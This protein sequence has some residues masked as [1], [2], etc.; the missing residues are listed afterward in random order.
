MAQKAWDEG[1][2]PG[3]TKGRLKR[4]LD[5]KAKKYIYSDVR[6][7][8]EYLYFYV[9]TCPGYVLVTVYQVPNDLKGLIP[10]GKDEV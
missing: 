4:F 9:R 3:V 8:G 7:H 6:I 10:R 5:S 1:I 2:P